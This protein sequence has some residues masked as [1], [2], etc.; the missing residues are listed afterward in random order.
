MRWSDTMLMGDGF[1]EGGSLL[2]LSCVDRRKCY[3]LFLEML[4]FSRGALTDSSGDAS[5]LCSLF[6]Q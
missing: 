1:R 3:F 4:L 6:K 5:I 2:V